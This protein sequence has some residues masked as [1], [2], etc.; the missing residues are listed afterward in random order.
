MRAGVNGRF[1][2]SMT[3]SA[4]AEMS[5]TVALTW[6]MAIRRWGTARAYDATSSRKTDCER[7]ESRIPTSD[8]RAVKRGAQ[9][10]TLLLHHER[11]LAAWTSR[12]SSFC[13]RLKSATC[14]SSACGSPMFLVPEIGRC[15]TCRAREA[16]SPKAWV[17]TVRRSRASPGSM[18]RTCWHILTHRP[19]RFCR[20]ATSAR[21]PRGCSATSRCRTARPRTPIPAMC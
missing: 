21:P 11:Q 8:A 16:H 5:P 10:V 12:P 17:S 2:H 9:A 14:G 7:R 6:A 15:R 13:G 1:D 4:L 3:T 18:S 19:S 20:G